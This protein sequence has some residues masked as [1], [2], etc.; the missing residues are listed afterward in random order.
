MP[1]LDL[2]EK[3]Q[4]EGRCFEINN[5]KI[6]DDDEKPMV[7][8]NDLLQRV[9]ERIGEDAVYSFEI[10]EDSQPDEVAQDIKLGLYCI[11]KL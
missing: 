7:S 11:S 9:S 2:E 10:Y 6:V 5:R 3:F 8:V 4:W 1:E